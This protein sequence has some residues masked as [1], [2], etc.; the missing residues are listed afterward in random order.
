[1]I[2]SSWTLFKRLW[3]ILNISCEWICSDCIGSVCCSAAIGSQRWGTTQRH[4]GYIKCFERDLTAHRT[5]YNSGTRYSKNVVTALR[6]LSRRRCVGTSSDILK[7]QDDGFL[8]VGPAHIK[9]NLSLLISTSQI[10]IATV[11]QHQHLQTFFLRRLISSINWTI[12]KLRW[13]Q[14]SLL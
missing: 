4:S 7:S 9:K 10:T 12:S 11:Q 8:L 13:V 1:M 3:S 2:C 14:L 5:R 6:P